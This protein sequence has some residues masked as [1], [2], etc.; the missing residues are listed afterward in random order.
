MSNFYCPVPL[1]PS[2]GGRWL[3]TV[4]PQTDEGALDLCFAF[5]QSLNQKPKSTPHPSEQRHALPPSG[6][7]NQP[8]RTKRKA[9]F[10]LS[11]RPQRGE[12]FIS[13]I[14]STHRF[15][16][17][18]RSSLA[19]APNHCSTIVQP[20]LNAL[21]HA[22]RLPI[23]CQRPCPCHRPCPYP[24]FAAAPNHCS[25]IVQLL[26]NNRSTM[27]HWLKKPPLYSHG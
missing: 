23:V 21:A 13:K 25:T 2:L 16:N 7:N 11:G 14:N 3:R 10:W 20:L 22:N 8:I 5:L 17:G 6:C 9:L 12:G 15:S 1:K 18:F 27:D 4:P 19:V 24:S 26:F